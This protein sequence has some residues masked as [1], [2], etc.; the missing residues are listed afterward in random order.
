[1]IPNIIHNIWL[2]QESP[3]SYNSLVPAC[4]ESQKRINSTFSFKWWGSNTFNE[5]IPHFSSLSTS[6]N[7]LWIRLNKCHAADINAKKADLLR[8]M[9]LYVYGG[10]Y[11]DL[12]IF[13]IRSLEKFRS[14]SIVLMEVGHN[15]FVVGEGLIGCCP[16]DYRMLDL[17]ASYTS[18]KWYKGEPWSGIT[19]KCKAYLKTRDIISLP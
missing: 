12:D 6:I 16:K 19:L 15:P 9:I 11:L 14:E 2:N 7:G 10:F 4:L 13:C 3:E 18:N 8:F 17:I 1:M 5:L